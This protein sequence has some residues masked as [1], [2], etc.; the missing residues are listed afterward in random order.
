MALARRRADTLQVLLHDKTLYRDRTRPAPG[1]GIKALPGD[2]TNTIDAPLDLSMHGEHVIHLGLGG[3][4]PRIAAKTACAWS[5]KTEAP[6]IHSLR[7]QL[8][9]WS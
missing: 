9:A 5:S 3:V 1:G 7:T 4:H 8:N 2:L 6:G